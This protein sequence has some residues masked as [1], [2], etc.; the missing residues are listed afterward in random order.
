MSM[1]RRVSAA[2]VFGLIVAAGLV[3]CAAADAP[4]APAPQARSFNFTNGPASPGTIIVRIE[5]LGSRV[6]STDPEAGL[7]AIHGKVRDLPICDNAST[8]VPVDLQ[9]VQTPSDAQAMALLI[10]AK[11]N[12]VAI[13][14]PP[15]E[16]LADLVVAL[17]DVNALCAFIAANKPVY[18]G[19]VQYRLHINGQTSFHFQWLGFL[20][21]VADGARFHYVENQHVVANGDGTLKTVAETIRLR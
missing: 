7:L 9:L 13:Y 5:G 4:T 10:T 14:D 17:L 11:E 8:R 20:E 12:D 19:T 21:R 1:L 6:I 16:Q 18:E 2:G 15:D 3:G